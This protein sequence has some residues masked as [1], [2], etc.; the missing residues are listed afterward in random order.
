[1]LCCDVRLLELVE[2]DLTLSGRCCCLEDDLEGSPPEV[3]GPRPLP[4]DTVLD[5][6]DP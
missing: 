2:L 6:D 5:D 1:M 3:T 4:E